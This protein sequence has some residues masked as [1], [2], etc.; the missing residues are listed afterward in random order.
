[1]I[2][3][4]RPQPGEFAPYYDQYIA[5]VPKGNL[6]DILAGQGK[7]FGAMVRAIPEGRGSFRYEPAK[8]S[9]NQVVGHVCDAERIFTYRALC[10]SR[11]EQAA[12]P[13]FDQNAYVPASA[14]EQRH[15]A[16]LGAEFEA[17]RAATLTL[18]H[19][20]TESMFMHKGTASGNPVTVRAIAYI[21]AGHCFHHAAILKER[22]L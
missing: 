14:A 15:I 13:G 1:M 7:D 4:A 10:F 21:V 11:G 6:L 19:G 12:L 16:D 17:I 5:R 20:M 3:I 8:W 22:Y 18:F 9:V 2:D